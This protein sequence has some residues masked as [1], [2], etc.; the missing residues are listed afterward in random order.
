MNIINSLTNYKFS[1]CDELNILRIDLSNIKHHSC[2]YNKLSQKE[3]EKAMKLRLERDRNR[4][5]ISH[6]VLRS[7]LAMYMNEEED[8]LDFRISKYGKPSLPSLDDH[9]N[10]HFNLSHSK[11]SF[12]FIFSPKSEVGIDIEFIQPYFEWRSLAKDFFNIDENNYL[13]SFDAEYQ[14]R[15]FYRLWTRKEA[16]LKAAG[17]GLS[18]ME[19]MEAYDKFNIVS[20]EFGTEYIGA[21][22]TESA[23][24]SYKFFDLNN[25]D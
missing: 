5:I 2:Y 19:N 7:L 3:K 14:T 1:L 10:I 18:G 16:V 24:Q 23:I 20:F 11:D 4:Y 8:T 21:F 17:I 25:L 13:N 9:R 22:S 6:G 15:E 12:C